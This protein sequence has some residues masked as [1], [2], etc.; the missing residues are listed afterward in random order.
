MR[1]RDELW[2]W[3]YG[4][5]EGL[6]VAEIQ[7]RA[8]GWS[9]WRD[10]CPDGEKAADVGARAD[11][12]IA[13]LLPLGGDVAVFSH[14]HMLRVLAARWIALNPEN[15]ARLALSTGSISVLGYER[16]TAVVGEWN[17]SPATLD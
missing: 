11:R 16:E 7:A 2:E 13:D 1:T 17:L 10:G 6:T 3:D 8:P 14:G 5:Y 9:L 12:L 4:S 15:G